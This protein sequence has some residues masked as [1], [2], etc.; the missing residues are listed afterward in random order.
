MWTLLLFMF[1]HVFFCKYSLF[2]SLLQKNVLTL[3]WYLTEW[4]KQTFEVLKIHSLL[5]DRKLPN[6]IIMH[7]LPLFISFDECL[8]KIRGDIWGNFSVSITLKQMKIFS[9]NIRNPVS[10]VN[11]IFQKN[12]C[13]PKPFCKILQTPPSLPFFAWIF[14]FVITSEQTKKTTG[15]EVQLEVV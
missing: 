14:S 4:G 9:C 10:P 2:I 15:G 7:I 13:I 8:L 11:L 3:A 1:F 6:V 5:Y 12:N